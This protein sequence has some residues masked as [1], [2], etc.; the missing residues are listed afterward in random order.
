MTIN[1][2]LAE[3]LLAE[4]RLLNSNIIEL[5]NALK[6]FEQSKSAKPKSSKLAPLTPE[7]RLELQ[8]KFEYLYEL[9]LAGHEFEVQ[10][11]LETFSVEEAR[12]L[13]DANNL[14]VT[15]KMSKEKV[16]NLIGIRFREKK[17]LNSNLTA[18]KPFSEGLQIQQTLTEPKEEMSEKTA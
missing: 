18:T 1:D 3:Q 5:I 9:W 17:M 16:L 12:R 7:E 2:K 4:L 13:A 14:N 15:S 6:Q 10:K 11:E 8:N